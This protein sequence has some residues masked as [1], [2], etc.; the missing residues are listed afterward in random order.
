MPGRPAAID[1]YVRQGITIGGVD[2]VICAATIDLVDECRRLLERGV[3]EHGLW[4][5]QRSGHPGL[6]GDA[7]LTSP[8]VDL[9][10]RTM[11]G[12]VEL[13]DDAT[14]R[15]VAVPAALTAQRLAE[16]LDGHLPR[17]AFYQEGVGYTADPRFDVEA[18]Y[19]RVA[20]A[21]LES[22][23]EPAEVSA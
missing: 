9:P 14:P 6:M 23:A 2:V 19:L 18:Y 3:N 15:S 8:I 7:V 1:N 20:E 11:L 22:L 4:I 16:E 10:T 21:I 13:A 17:M 12:Y 5:L